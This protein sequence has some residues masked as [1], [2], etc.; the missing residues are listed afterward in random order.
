M[1]TGNTRTMIF[2][3]ARLVS[4]ISRYWTDESSDAAM[5]YAENRRANMVN[6]LHPRVDGD[7]Q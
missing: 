2:S 7:R 3:V 5:L 6:R 1:R 4:Y